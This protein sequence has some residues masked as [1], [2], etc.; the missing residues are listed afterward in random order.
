MTTVQLETL[1]RNI[2]KTKNIIVDDNEEIYGEYHEFY[3]DEFSDLIPEDTIIKIQNIADLMIAVGEVEDKDVI[4]NTYIIYRNDT[5]PY[6]IILIDEDEE[7]QT[8]SVL[9]GKWTCC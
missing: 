1:T 8:Y 5:V 7:R 6:F 2:L 3:L 4:Y 9:E